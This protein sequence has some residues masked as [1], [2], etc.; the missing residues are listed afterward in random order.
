[1]NNKK[2]TMNKVS[3]F[4]DNIFFGSWPLKYRKYKT[5]LLNQKKYVL[6]DIRPKSDFETNQ[7]IKGAINVSRILWDD[8]I[9]NVLQ[10]HKNKKII[11]IS[12]TGRECP[13]YVRELKNM[14][15]RKI[16]ILLGGLE[17]IGYKSR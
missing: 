2:T 8:K 5:K 15:Y 14:G 12:E 9:D 10:D 16:Y 13:R 17:S 4:F 7:S 3:E 11:L 1:M 6:I